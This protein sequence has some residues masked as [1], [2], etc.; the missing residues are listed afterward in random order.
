MEPAERLG[1]RPP[2]AAAGRVTHVRQDVAG[3]EILDVHILDNAHDLRELAV[4]GL[5]LQQALGI[6]GV[7]RGD[8]ATKLG[9]MRHVA[10]G[11]REAEP[12]AMQVLARRHRSHVRAMPTGRRGTRC[13]RPAKRSA[14]GT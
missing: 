3:I 9:A 7:D 14:A 8:P 5:C 11:R 13:A 1:R 10:V 2:Y 6:R 4:E 12:V